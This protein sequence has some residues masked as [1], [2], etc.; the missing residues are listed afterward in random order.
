[1]VLISVDGF[2]KQ[3]QSNMDKDIILNDKML[4]INAQEF[5]KILSHFFGFVL[6]IPTYLS[7]P[8]QYNLCAS[9]KP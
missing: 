8:S 3:P 4:H 9:Y 7:D 5:K 6:P 2:F 1:M